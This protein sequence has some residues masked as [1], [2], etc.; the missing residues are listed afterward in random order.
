MNTLRARTIRLAHQ[1]PDLR[2]ILLP[3]LKTAMEHATP[4]A[5]EKYLK[6][7]PNADPK[8]HAV[9]GK[10]EG[11]GKSEAPAKEK[12]AHVQG[13]KNLGGA[14]QEWQGPGTPGIN[15]AGSYF[16]SGKPVPRDTAEK[17]HKEIKQMLSEAGSRGTPDD[18]VKH[19]KKID[20]ALKKILK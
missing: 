1:N 12:P 3:L 14:L 16:T 18:H 17:A 8:N 6:E 9:K 13:D 11:G 7:H 4:E 15:S 5:R 2:P 19:L 10:S 20:S